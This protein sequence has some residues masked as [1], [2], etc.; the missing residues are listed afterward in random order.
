MHLLRPYRIEYCEEEYYDLR[1]V[2]LLF[3]EP[4]HQ[5]ECTDLDILECVK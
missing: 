4:L 3:F 1:A 5:P 2:V